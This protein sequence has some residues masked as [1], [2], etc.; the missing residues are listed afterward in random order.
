MR[1]Q[2][3]SSS[4]LAAED[5]VHAAAACLRRAENFWQ[6]EIAAHTSHGLDTRVRCVDLGR[7]R[8]IA[9]PSASLPVYSFDFGVVVGVVC[10]AFYRQSLRRRNA[11]TFWCSVEREVNENRKVDAVTENRDS[12]HK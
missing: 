8:V 12:E 10:Y 3:A 9:S 2:Y 4:L 11:I 5:Y 6:V 1:S 7:E